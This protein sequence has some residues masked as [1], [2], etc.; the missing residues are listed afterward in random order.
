M[1]YFSSDLS[2][3]LHGCVRRQGKFHPKTGGFIAEHGNGNPCLS[4]KSQYV[5]YAAPPRFDHPCSEKGVGDIGVEGLRRVF[6]QKR[7]HSP[8]VIEF[9]WPPNYFQ[10]HYRSV[11]RKVPE[12][13]P[14]TIRSGLAE[15]M[16]SSRG[17][18]A[19]PGCACSLPFKN[20]Q[21]DALILLRFRGLH[22]LWDGLP[23]I[24]IKN[25]PCELDEVLQV[26]G[27]IFLLVVCNVYGVTIIK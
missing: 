17:V 14:W 8:V 20:L 3:D 15:T 22:N 13:P 1:T 23:W 6:P 4:A 5:L 7:L 24:T 2:C 27:G 16:L 21:I 10:G 25:H 18:R 12:H 9:G 11:P 26:C 19:L